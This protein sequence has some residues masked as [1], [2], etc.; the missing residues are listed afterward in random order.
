MNFFKRR[1]N[2]KGF[3]LVELLIV[4][5][6]LGIIAGIG[7]NSMSGITD[8]FKEKADAQTC[9]Q[10]AR[11]IEVQVLAGTLDLSKHTKLESGDVDEIG[12]THSQSVANTPFIVTVQEKTGDTG[13]Y[14]LVFTITGNDFSHTVDIA[15]SSV[16][17]SN[18]DTTTKPV[19]VD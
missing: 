1:L 12:T 4:I 17:G 7:V 5:A 3:T 9:E 14:E 19:V 6:V 13:N 10:L 11:V 18:T 8:T 15:D 16:D 2:K